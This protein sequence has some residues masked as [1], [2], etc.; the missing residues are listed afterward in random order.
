MNTR[1]PMLLELQRAVY[2]SVIARDGAEGSAYV[3]A[4]G[5]APAARL[6]I[7]R[8]TFASVLTTALRLSYPALHRLVAAECFEGAARLFIEERPPQCANLDDYGSGFP[9]FL[10]RFPPAAALTYLPDVA[11]LEWALNRALH[12]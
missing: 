1:A 9:E 5:I 12:A 10:A 2:R 3:I 7:H 6:G 4:D 8:N 11:R